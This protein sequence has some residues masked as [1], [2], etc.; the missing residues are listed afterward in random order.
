MV[1][2]VVT[3]TFRMRN[4]V[5]L[6]F[7]F[8]QNFDRTIFDPSKVKIYQNSPV[9]TSEGSNIRRVVLVAREWLTRL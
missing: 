3:G 4:V 1:N 2:H 7:A 8:F 6:L 5:L 9:L